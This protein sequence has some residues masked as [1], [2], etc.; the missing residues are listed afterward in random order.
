VYV[1]LKD[2]VKK[3]YEVA[4]DAFVV[5]IKISA[6]EAGGA[7]LVQVVPLLVS[8]FPLLPGAGNAVVCVVLSGN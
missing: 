7:A 5:A 4:P 8:T 1:L 3:S 6:P 2:D